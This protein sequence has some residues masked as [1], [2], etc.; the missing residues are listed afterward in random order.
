M[1]P[2]RAAYAVVLLALVGDARVPHAKTSGDMDR[3][4]REPLVGR[5][6]VQNKS[7]PAVLRGAMA[8]GW[9]ERWAA[10][11]YLASALAGEMLNNVESYPGQFGSAYP[12]MTYGD[13][14]EHRE[15]GYEEF[16]ARLAS[17]AQREE[18]C[19]LADCEIGRGGEPST[20]C[21]TAAAARRLLGDLDGGGRA[22]PDIA[23]LAGAGRDAAVRL[24]VGN[25]STTQ[26]HYDGVFD[27][28]IVQVRGAKRIVV[29]PPSATAAVGVDPAV[30]ACRFGASEIGRGSAWNPAYAL[31]A[32]GARQFEN[33]RP[34]D[35]VYVP[36]HWW[37]AVYGD[38][39]PPGGA[40]ALTVSY[41]YKAPGALALADVLADGP[42]AGTRALN[43]DA[44][45]E[46][47]ACPRALLAGGPFERPGDRT[48]AR[49]R[50]APRRD[51]DYRFRRGRDVLP[52]RYS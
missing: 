13:R 27:A 44:S 2:G 50:T 9:V 17:P 52:R 19:Y 33:L 21:V 1:V 26:F 23:G 29:A 38:P 46:Q 35:A 51:R 34:G 4:L 36:R 16:A 30:G 47:L 11:D 49:G 12:K 6:S 37:H 5:R 14:V 43:P 48:A 31:R 7:E 15:V 45:E 39:A 32:P 40:P 3:V 20:T 24:F 22:V 41:F 8:G 28:L 18:P 42:A 10:P 25:W